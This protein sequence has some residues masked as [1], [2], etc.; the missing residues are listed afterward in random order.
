MQE[1]PVAEE[2]TNHDAETEEDLQNKTNNEQEEQP[3]T[4]VDNEDTPETPKEENAEESPSQAQ[5]EESK[6]KEHKNAEIER[7]K[8]PS[9]ENHSALFSTFSVAVDPWKGKESV[10]YF[11]ADSNVAVYDNCGG[12]PLKKVGELVKGQVY[13]RVSDYGNWHRIDFGSFYGYVRKSE[14]SPA[15]GNAI[16][17]ENKNYK[18]QSRTFTAL[19]DVM[20]YDNTSGKLVPFGTIDKGQTYPIASDYG[21]WWRVI[22]S[23]RVGYVRKSDVQIGFTKS[24]KYFRAD[25]NVAVYDNRG[26]G[27]LK[28]VGELVKGQVYPRVSDY[29]N[30]HRIDFGNFYGYVKK[31]ETSPASGSA[32]KNENK[33]YKD[34]SRTFTALK[35]VM[36]YDNTSGKLVPF[37]TIDKGQTYPIASDFGNW[38]RVI[39]SDRVGYVRKSDVQLGFTK[40]DKYFR[41]DSNTSVYDN[42]SGSLKKVGELV[43][44][45]VYLR[46]S[47]Y[48]NWHRID[49][50]NFYGYVKKSETSPASG[51]AIKNENKKY[52]DQSRTFTALKDV[53]VYDN[54]SGKLVPFGTIDKGQRFPIAADYG[55]WWIILYSDRVGYIKK[56]EV[57]VQVK[58]TDKYFRVF[59]NLPVYE[60]LTGSL[61]KVGELVKGQSY[62]IHSDY[63]NWWRVEFGNIYGYVRKSDTGYATKSEITNL[64]N[65]YKNSNRKFIS[66]S[67]ITIYD[68]SSGKLIPFGTIEKEQVFPIVSDYGN[69]WRIIYLNRIGYIRKNDVLTNS[70]SEYEIDRV[71]TKYKNIG[72]SEYISKIKQFFTSPSNNYIEVANN[73]LLKDV[74]RIASYGTYDFSKGIPWGESPVKGTELSRSYYRALHGHFFVNDLVAAYK[75]TRDKK[76]IN[77]GFEI[78]ED[79]ITK[80]PYGNSQH[81]LAWHDE[82]TAR[83]LITWVNFYDAARDVLKVEQLKFLLKNMIQHADLLLHNGFHS[84]NTNHGMF[85]DEALLV[86]S[87]YFPAL[88]NSNKYYNVSKKRLKDYFNFIISK[89]GVHLEHSPSYHQIIAESVEGY[90]EY[91]RLNND[92]Q[93]YNYYNNLYNLMA[94][95]SIWVIKPDGYLPAI[96]DTF[97]NLKPSNSLWRDNPYYRYSITG[98]KEGNKP[99]E[100]SKVYKDAGYAIIRDDWEKGRDAT[101]IHFTAAY[102][103]QYHKH[104]DDLSVWI[105][106][107]GYDIITEAG[108]NGYDYDKPFTEFG[109]SS[110]AHNTLIVNNQGLPRVD[111]QYNKTYLLDD[112][113]LSESYNKVS[114]INKRYKNVTHQRDLEYDSVSKEIKVTDSIT[115]SEKNNYK[116]L[117]NLAEGVVPV[118]NDNSIELFIEGTKV[119]E[120]EIN[121]T[122]KYKISQV[123]G[124][125]S[126]YIV[127][128]HIKGQDNI[129]KTHTIVIEVEDSSTV[130]E[131]LFRIE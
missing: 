73:I 76:Y 19:K 28:K 58:G 116:I 77:K 91:F 71:V 51:S 101:Y 93:E 95:Y 12:G 4:D 39:Y 109:Y 43:K 112:Y 127:G 107:N 67:K 80:N 123:I 131:S 59:D 83:R 57:K 105:Y 54:T 63:G 40:S 64:N 60:N 126:P 30:W 110:F 46:V 11:R 14:T 129:V 5:V 119:M 53:T 124:Q 81:S 115:S 125:I 52:K 35:D 25:N 47:D 17:N 65:G 42:R 97:Y 8:S 113:Y 106:A 20:V 104:S 37:G 85:Q 68:N 22:F 32:I 50:G 92:Y 6:A 15:S 74:Y 120:M 26:G 117:W 13:P 100:N 103:T 18:D 41:A 118:I 27:P 9:L 29:G 36:V 88:E 34:Q 23:D 69:W 121:S 114:G 38:W 89:E 48:G 7:E 44:G 1:A 94:N 102:H 122:S 55:K 87:T 66:P 128:W 10:K 130:I 82:G 49:F 111:G 45:Q 86:F 96:G 70:T 72:T 84:T 79:W 3:N 31:S 108:P 56:E 16:K 33:N 75:K 61:K 62:P 2:G 98:G 99:S 24:D 21:N 90:K 78:I